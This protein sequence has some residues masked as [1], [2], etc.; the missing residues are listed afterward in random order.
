MI[1]EKS[2]P[3]IEVVSY[4]SG[5]PK[6]FEQEAKKLRTIFGK[7]LLLIKHYGSTSIPGMLAKPIIDILLGV[8]TIE[9]ADSMNQ[10][11]LA[12]N[13]IAQGEFGVKGRRFFTKSN[14]IRRLCH[15]S[16]FA[17]DNQELLRQVRFNDYLRI[18]SKEAQQYS[19]LKQQL[20]NQYAYDAKGY[21]NAKREFIAELHLKAEIW[22]KEHRLCQ[23]IK[24]YLGFDNTVGDFARH[25]C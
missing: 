22:E 6:L 15:L 19:Q 1:K 20:A 18:H 25:S 23:T 3:E 17:M 5:W 8:K 12:I 4:K 9:V 10:S 7:N 2:K 13:Y 11:L 24:C 14:A 16:I 21:S